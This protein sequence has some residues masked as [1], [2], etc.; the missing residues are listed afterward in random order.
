MDA[1]VA[2]EEERRGL[3]EEFDVD[4]GDVAD[5]VGVVVQH[6][7]RGYAFVQEQCEGFRQ[8]SVATG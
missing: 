5:D 6:G 8:R 2:E 7:K 1:G 4:N 3:G